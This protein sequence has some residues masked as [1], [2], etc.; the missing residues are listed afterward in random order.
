MI[1]RMSHPWDGVKNVLS[2]RWCEECAILKMVWRMLH[3]W[4]DLKNVLSLRW[5]EEYP[6][7]EIV[8]GMSHPWGGVRNVP[9]LRWCKECTSLSPCSSSNLGNTLDKLSREPFP[10]MPQCYYSKLW[11]PSWWWN[12][13]KLLN[14]K[15]M[16]E[17]RLVKLMWH[18]VNHEA[19]KMH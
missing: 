17:T 2:L 11:K 14:Q 5:C 3:P 7:L 10:S 13:L 4:N 15:S 8:W 1:W 9:S 19:E 16:R 12:S 18:S 6:I